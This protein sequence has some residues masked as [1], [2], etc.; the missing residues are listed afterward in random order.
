MNS[1]NPSAVM[2]AQQSSSTRHALRLAVL[3]TA[4]NVLGCL[5]GADTADYSNKVMFTDRVHVMAVR[6]SNSRDASVALPAPFAPAGA[7]LTYHGGKVIQSV[8]ITQVLYESGTYI[9]ELTST[10]GVNMANAYTQM[11]TSGVFDWLN[12]YNTASP[13]QALGRGAQVVASVAGMVLPAC[14][15]SGSAAS[16]GLE[17]LARQI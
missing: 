13:A 1:V 6:D 3:L 15:D 10:S 11:A 8:H 7:H 2:L 9:P 14:D 12:E 5:A 16:A 4:T 17:G